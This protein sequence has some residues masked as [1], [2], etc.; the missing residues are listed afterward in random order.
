[1]ADIS[2]N[3]LTITKK[4]NFNGWYICFKNHSKIKIPF[5]VILIAYISDD[6]THNYKK[7]NLMACITISKIIL[8]QN[9]LF[10][11]FD[12]Q[13]NYFDNHFGIK[14]LFLVTLI[15]YINIDGTHNY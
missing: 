15:D 8:K 3:G 13:Y 1:M 6:K 5:L 7:K 2:D 9:F 11:N 4:G 10:S 12:G 14:F